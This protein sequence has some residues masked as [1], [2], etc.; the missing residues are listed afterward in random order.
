M[1]L[2]N[3]SPKSSSACRLCGDTTHLYL[4]NVRGHNLEK[5]PTCGFVQVAEPPDPLEVEE[6]YRKAYFNH[7]KYRDKDTLNTENVRRLKILTGAVQKNARVLEVGCGE[8]SF[9]KLVKSHYQISGF[10]LSQTGID[11]AREQNPDIADRIQVAKI[12]DYSNTENQ[13]DAICM[14]DVLEH[15]WDPAPTCEKLIKLLKPGGKLL[16]S[17]PNI[18]ALIAWV[19]RKRWAFMTPPEHLSFFGPQSVHYLFEDR[20]ESRV[21]DLRSKGKKV[22]LGFFLYKLKRVFP[23]LPGLIHK[24]VERSPALSKAAFYIPTGDIQY[25]VIEKG[26][27]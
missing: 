9:I 12:E 19:M 18:N 14:W 26:Q 7:D 10:D 21:V 20:L 1:P 27:F 6:I 2:N 22:N 16:I 8:G 17:T 5:C 15:I 4:T 24:W 11:I 25:I 3:V 13:F 23:K